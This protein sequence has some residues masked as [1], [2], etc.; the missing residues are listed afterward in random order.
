MAA[1][2][3]A[4]A[5]ARLT[6][7]LLGMLPCTGVT[8]SVF[9][10]AANLALRRGGH[11]RLVTLVPWGTPG[12]PDG[13]AVPEALLAGLRENA[14]AAL[15]C[16][17]LRIGDCT[18]PL[19]Q[20]DCGA[21]LL[22]P[23]TGVLR[24]EAFL[25]TQAWQGHGLQRLPPA[26][27]RDAQRALQAGQGRWLGLGPGLTPSFDD[28]CVG[29][30]ALHRAAGKPQPFGLLDLS[31]TTDVSARYLALAMEGYFSQLVLDVTAA[32]Y[33]EK[34]DLPKSVDALSRLGKTS[35]RDLLL[36]IRQAMEALSL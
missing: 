18:L 11:M 30:M 36:G 19:A 21:L 10:H 29:A 27:G 33:D 7:F 8:H 16:D 32:L 25:R 6:P 17:A 1:E 20:M 5:A 3:G 28:A 34:L 13:I 23:Q 15:S 22:R 24:R 9:A 14:P 12:V 31:R 2:L 4:S 26:I 35:G